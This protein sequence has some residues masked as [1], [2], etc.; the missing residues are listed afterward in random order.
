MKTLPVL[1]FVAALA[2][3]VFAPIT[4]ELVGALVLAV[5]LGG[6]FF[7]DYTRRAAPI[8]APSAAVVRLTRASRTAQRIELAA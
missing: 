6:I 4:I 2:A 1:V 7:A 5:G 3:F 8:V